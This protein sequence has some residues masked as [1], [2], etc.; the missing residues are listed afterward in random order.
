V[1]Q[2]GGNIQALI[3]GVL[4][5]AGLAVAGVLVGSGMKAFK[6]DV[7]SVTVKGLVERE[8]K[9]DEAVW[10]LSFSR[11]GDSL[12]DTH[13]AL[14]A[15]R[16]AVL[17]FLH[18]RG[19][20][21]GDIQVQPT[22]SVDRLAQ[23]YGEERRPRARYVVAASVVVRSADIA[24]VQSSSGATDALLAKG[25]VL[26]GASQGRANPHYV[27][28]KFND[29]RPQ[30]L[31][32]ATRN[33]RSIATQFAADSGAAVGGIRNAN[34]GNIQIFGS[35]GNDESAAWSP[36]STPTKKIRVVSTFEFELK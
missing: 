28:A 22:R 4:A 19:F 12:K 5:A 17:A 9:A 15:D 35:D 34:Q 31:A 11:A 29:L 10:T 3:I 8:L 24:R 14:S 26:D 16:E 6:A 33:A 21:D 1:A 18:A 20:A 7:R 13:A 25:I 2:N 36:T 30:L 32:E 23:E 27:L